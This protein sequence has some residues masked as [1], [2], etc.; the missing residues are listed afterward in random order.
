MLLN[1][2]KIIV[3]ITFLSLVFGTVILQAKQKTQT[4]KLK[5]KATTHFRAVGPY[6][7]L[8]PDG[9]KGALQNYMKVVELQPDHVESLKG[10]AEIHFDLA[11]YGEDNNEE[12]TLNLLLQSN[13]AFKKVIATIYSIPEWETYIDSK[14][15]SFEDLLSD[16][17][18][19][20]ESIWVN[21]YKFAEE[22]FISE[23]D[24]NPNEKRDLERAEEIYLTLIELDKTRDPSYIRLA[25]IEKERGNI[26][27]STEYFIKLYEVDTTNT[28]VI[29][30][31]AQEYEIAKDWENAIIYYE[32][33]INIE[34]NNA[35]VHGALGRVSLELDDLDTALIH[36]TNAH[37]IDPENIDILYDA[38]NVA[39]SL[40]K[41][42]L[43][44][45]YLKKLVEIEPTEENISIICYQLRKMR[46]WRELIIYS[47]KWYELDETNRVPVQFIIH[48]TI[49]LKDSNLQRE[50]ESILNKMK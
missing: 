5:G 23:E 12:E 2:K 48:S 11:L 37:N 45:S 1:I 28:L 30:K 3:M 27:K 20:K 36:Y 18:K 35:E 46:E 16:S 4:Q 44:V 47:K 33:L 50:Y 40:H 7:Q 42:D 24:G 8:G 10:I 34:P 43:I 9:Y 17:K 31:I 25:A 21:I 13:D 26:E 6:L 14:K 22:Y 39:V 41:D 29:K 49:E 15:H 38:F 19:K 32:K